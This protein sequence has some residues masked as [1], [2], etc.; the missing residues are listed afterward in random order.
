MIG[1]PGA[2]D[3]A[4]VSATVSTLWSVEDEATRAFMSVYYK[5]LWGPGRHKGPGLAL[6]MAQRDMIR[7]Q[8]TSASGVPVDKPSQWA[9]FIL[10]GDP[11]VPPAAS[12]A[13]QR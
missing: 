12:P 13:T 1:L 3:R 2:M 11:F 7:R 4:G 8:V 9:A 5:H 6:S 10:V